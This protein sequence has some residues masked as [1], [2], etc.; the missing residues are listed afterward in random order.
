MLETVVHWN[1]YG[2]GRDA[3]L[4]KLRVSSR[5]DGKT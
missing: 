4:V 5:G 1:A 2:S 3:D